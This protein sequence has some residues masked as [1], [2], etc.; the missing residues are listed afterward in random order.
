MSTLGLL[1]V[2]VLPGAFLIF[3]GVGHLWNYVR[4]RRT[5]P[6]DIRQVDSSSGEVKL[7][8]TARVHNE[9]SRSP[10]TDTRAL[11]HKWKVKASSSSG[12]DGSSHPQLDSGEATHSFLLE[13]ETG[14]VLVDTEGATPYLRTTTTI[15]VAPDASPPPSIAQFLQSTDE[16]DPDPDRTRRYIESRLDPGSRV[17]VFG[18]IR[19][20]RSSDD[21]PPSV[22][23]VVGGEESRRD[24]AMKDLTL[25]TIIAQLTTQPEQFIITN[26]DEDGAERQ[27][28]TIGGV[29]LGVGLLF[30]GV[31]GLLLVG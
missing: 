15:D 21:C 24:R 11:I 1:L 7:T 31:T 14:T 18:P 29:S 12:S 28:L 23:A 16:V 6:T 13:D 4:L 25:S 27:M 2:G 5:T 30:L 10:F 9:T 19:E 17:H 26:G 20:P 22:D 8:G 3:I